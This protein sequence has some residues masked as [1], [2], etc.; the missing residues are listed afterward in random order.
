MVIITYVAPLHDWL[1]R[2]ARAFFSGRKA[3]SVS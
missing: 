2:I 1:Q 3:F